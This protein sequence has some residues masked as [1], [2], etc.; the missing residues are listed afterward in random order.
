M[1][2]ESPKIKVMIADDH[3]VLR[4]ALASLINGFGEFN[5]IALAC[6]GEEV[7]THLSEKKIPDIIVLDLNM[8]IMNGYEIA[9]ILYEKYPEINIL[10]LTMY[11]SEIALIRLLHLG[12]KGF[13]KKDIHPFELKK[14]LLVVADSQYYYSN[15]SMDH[16]TGMVRKNKHLTIGQ[17]LLNETEIEFLRFS[18]TEMTY[19]E[20]ANVMDMTPRR[21][22]H[23]R[24][25]LFEKLDIK[26]RV[27]LAMYAI[28]HGFV[29][30]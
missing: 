13:L 3:I 25:I 11:D 19:K 1:K 10:I 20:I 6:N 2:K 27:G 16:L 14:A 12:V 21:I 5:V 24:D 18:S 23:Y 30:F 15:N 22:D 4:D 29:T 28:K 8:P 9:K 26:S 17:N 7:I